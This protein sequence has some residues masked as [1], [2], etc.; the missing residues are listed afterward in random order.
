[1]DGLTRALQVLVAVTTVGAAIVLAMDA[2]YGV[3]TGV[4]VVGALLVAAMVVAGRH[5][6]DRTNGQRGLS[7][8]LRLGHALSVVAV[9]AIT[10]GATPAV[11]GRDDG[12]G[13]TLV[14]WVGPMALAAAAGVYTTY[15]ALRREAASPRQA[16]PRQ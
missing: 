11:T 10:T 16:S 4:G 5:S 15:S 13:R 6:R 2:R 3:A 8:V 12:A 14:V 9:L 1:M 7:R